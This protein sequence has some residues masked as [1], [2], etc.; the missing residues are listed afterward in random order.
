MCVCVCVCVCDGGETERDRDRERETDRDTERGIH[1]YVLIYKSEYNI[2][3][4]Y[5]ILFVYQFLGI[6]FVYKIGPFSSNNL[7][8]K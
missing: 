2:H 4:N 5:G 1:M 6:I 7:I 3:M 8:L